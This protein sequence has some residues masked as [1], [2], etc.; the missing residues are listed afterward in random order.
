M[1]KQLT[2]NVKR[3]DDI[4]SVSI[5]ASMSEGLQRATS[6]GMLTVSDYVRLALRAVLVRDGYMPQP[7]PP[8]NGSTHQQAA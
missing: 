6:D 4:L 1:S 8:S 2:A 5:S 7:Q 3:F